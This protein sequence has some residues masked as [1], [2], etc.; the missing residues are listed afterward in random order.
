MVRSSLGLEGMSV[1]EK[2][3]VELLP[4]QIERLAS[5]LASQLNTSAKLRLAEQLNRQTRRARWQP[6]ALK[7]RRRFA[8]NPL[9]ARDIR[10]LCETVR[11]ERSERE[12][13]ARRR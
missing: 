3:L 11:R 10:R 5:R 7:M 6:L 9:S 2:V 1:M 13:R 4:K 8:R 12:E